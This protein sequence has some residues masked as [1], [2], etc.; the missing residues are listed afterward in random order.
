MRALSAVPFWASSNKNGDVTRNYKATLFWMGLLG[1][2]VGVGVVGKLMGLKNAEHEEK[3]VYDQ[4]LHGGLH[5][6]AGAATLLLGALA[7]FA[8]VSGFYGLYK[9]RKIATACRNSN[10]TGQSAGE[11]AVFSREFFNQKAVTAAIKAG[12]GLVFIGMA[13]AAIAINNT[14]GFPKMWQT[15]IDSDWAHGVAGTFVTLLTAA[16]VGLVGVGAHATG[17]K[18]W[19]TG[20]CGI[21]GKRGNYDPIPGDGSAID[22]KEQKKENRDLEI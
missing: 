15:L 4:D 17:G 10:L 18:L 3:H 13:V 14:I 8:V 16:G 19:E 9:R 1:I 22:L 5:Q 6:F 12:L 20:C 11:I 7:T 21:F 2:G